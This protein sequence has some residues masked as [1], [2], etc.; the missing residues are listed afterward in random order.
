MA[1]PIRCK[2]GKAFLPYDIPKECPKCGHKYFIPLRV[3]ENE[4]ETK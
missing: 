2:C 1:F 3:I 4:I